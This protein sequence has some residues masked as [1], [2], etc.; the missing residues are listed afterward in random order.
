MYTEDDCSHTYNAD[1][2]VKVSG[3]AA[4]MDIDEILQI[5]ETHSIDAVHPGYG[6]LSESAEF[7]RRLEQRGTL[8]IGPPAD[9]LDRT[10]DKLQARQLAESCRVPVLPALTSPTSDAAVIERFAE[11]VG[12][13]IMIKAVDGGGGRG[14]RLVEDLSSLEAGLARAIEESPSRKVFVEKAA[15]N[16]YRHIEVQIVGDG[17]GNIT[18]LWE[19][20]CSIQRRYQKVVELAPSTLPDRELVAA[21]IEAALKVAKKVS[22]QVAS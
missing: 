2:A 11:K 16:G 9:V 6:F 18:H 15:I 8:F 19:R 5:V 12:W 22:T 20:E 1:D 4:Y 13:P 3:P 14:I 17:H 10:G 7:A 21:V